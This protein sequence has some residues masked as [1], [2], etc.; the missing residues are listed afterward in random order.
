MIKV[1][2]QQ[3]TI[4]LINIYAPN[5]GAPQYVRQIL[6]DIKGKT[7]RVIVGN[8]NTP[9]TSID[10]SSRWKTNRETVA[11]NDILD[12]RDLIHIFGVI[13]SKTT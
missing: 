13:Y 3:E 12:Q 11:L 10:R 8:F 4:T 1:S 5:I 2:T 9:M 7:D 6:M